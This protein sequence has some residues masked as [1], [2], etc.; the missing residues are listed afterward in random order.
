MAVNIEI[1]LTIPQF[2][3]ARRS[4]RQSNECFPLFYPGI[5]PFLA[6]SAVKYCI[7]RVCNVLTYSLYAIW[8]HVIMHIVPFFRLLY[9][10]WFFLC[11]AHE[12]F[13]QSWRSAARNLKL[14]RTSGPN[15]QV[16]PSWTRNTART[17]TRLVFGRKLSSGWGF[18]SF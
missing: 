17:L 3:S 13:A 8:V 14:W 2:E 12:T 10:W 5:F 11:S 18:G 1:H 15:N 4:R 9:Y 7:K 16:L 6:K